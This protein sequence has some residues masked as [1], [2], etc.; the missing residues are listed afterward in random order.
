MPDP[1]LIL[2][3][4]YDT[5]RRDYGRAIGQRRDELIT[6]ALVLD[7][8]AAQRNIDHM[9]S[10]LKQM[11]A[12]TIRPHYKTHKSPDLARRQVAGRARA[13][14][15][16]PRCGRRRSWPPPGWTTCSWSTRWPIRPSSGSLAELARDHRMLVAVDE[17][18]NAA[19]RRPRPPSR[20]GRR[21]GIM[22][23]VDTGMDRCGTDNAADCLALARQVMDLP[24]LRFEGIT[25]YE[26]HCSH[27]AGPRSAARAPARGDDVLH[28]ASPGCWRRTGSPA[29]SGRPA[30]SPPGTG[31][32]PTRA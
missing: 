4:A 10:E 17:A 15:P 16:W 29:R 18:A 12:A 8:D 23:E 13:G 21:S 11:G 2:R 26:G 25:G 31:P 20:R 22:V 30:G 24:G 1:A 32:R 27:D 19:A 14:C 6:P 9:A 5:V 28:R 7:I 3:E